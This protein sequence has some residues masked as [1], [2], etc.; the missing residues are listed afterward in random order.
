MLAKLPMRQLCVLVILSLTA[1]ET[2]FTVSVNNQPVYDPDGRQASQTV[3]DADLQGCINLALRQQ[4]LND[5]ADITVL[6]CANSQITG[7]ENIGRLRS[8]RFL[9]VSNNNIVNI[10]PLEDLHQLGGLNL[11]NNRIIDV[12]PLLNISS[13]A[14][15]SLSGNDNIPCEQLRLLE[16]K[17]GNNLTRPANCKR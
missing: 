1:C 2:P 13:L 11:M 12:S 7:L 17:L 10:T 3:V 9:D 5:A 14:T 8:L 6:S 15:V 16:L 4:K